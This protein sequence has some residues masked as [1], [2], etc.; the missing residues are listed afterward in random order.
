MKGAGVD[1]LCE[2]RHAVNALDRNQYT[3]LIID[4]HTTYAVEVCRSLARLGYAVDIFA[5]RLSPGFRSRFCRRC[6]QSPSF[7]DAGEVTCALRDV[8]EQARYDVIYLCSEDLL[9][10]LAPILRTSG[11]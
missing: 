9:P 10:Q 3:A 5:E 11:S 2:S 6:L 7:H 1:P 4:Q 8:V